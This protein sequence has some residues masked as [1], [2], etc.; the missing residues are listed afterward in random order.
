VEAIEY[1]RNAAMKL[2]AIEYDCGDVTLTNYVAQDHS[3]SEQSSRNTFRLSVETGRPIGRRS[4][5][6]VCRLFGNRSAPVVG[7]IAVG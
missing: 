3:G 1:H 6:P 5:H 2:Q 7:V 4:L